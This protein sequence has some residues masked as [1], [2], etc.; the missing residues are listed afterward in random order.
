M[1]PFNLKGREEG[2]KTNPF[3]LVIKVTQGGG[4]SM[5]VPKPGAHLCVGPVWVTG[6]ESPRNLSLCLGDKGASGKEFTFEAKSP[7]MTSL[8]Q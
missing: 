7:G 6:G 3:F 5:A 4:R 2:K 8:D 1:L